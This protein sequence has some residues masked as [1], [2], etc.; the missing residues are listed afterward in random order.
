M[1]T[2][3][4]PKKRMGR[5]PKAK[6]PITEVV[7]REEKEQVH[8]ENQKREEVVATPVKTDFNPEA[9]REKP[10]PSISERIAES[11]KSLN[12]ILEEGQA[13]FETPEGEILIGQSDRDRM[14]SRT[15]N[16][17]KGG[18]CNKRR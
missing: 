14:W 7:Q 15:M 18:W 9:L 4:K 8:E 3:E 5:P 16:N 11:R 6:P 1:E 17:G 2:I 13:F 12:Q 10:G